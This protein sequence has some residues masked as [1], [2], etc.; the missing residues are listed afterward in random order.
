MHNVIQV[1]QKAMHAVNFDTHVY[2]CYKQIETE[3]EDAGNTTD[4]IL[5]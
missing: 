4:I 1:E 5:R 3:T 2:Y